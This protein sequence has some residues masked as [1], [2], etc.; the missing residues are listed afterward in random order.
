MGESIF[1][2]SLI[3]VFDL[4]T[5]KGKGLNIKKIKGGIDSLISTH[6]FK[7]DLKINMDEN[8]KSPIKVIEIAEYSLIP[9][10]LE[11]FALL[12]LAYLS[13]V[14]IFQVYCIHE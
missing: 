2:P 12:L 7:S 5:G 3:Y 6:W 9:G 11:R 1:I 10:F 4:K 14:E 8:G 13:D